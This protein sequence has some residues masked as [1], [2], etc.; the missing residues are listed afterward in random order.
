MDV[1]TGESEPESEWARRRARAS[2][3]DRHVEVLTEVGTSRARD[4]ERARARDEW[5]KKEKRGITRPR[6]EGEKRHGTKLQ[7]EDW[8]TKTFRKTHNSRET[9]LRSRA[10]LS[11]F[12]KYWKRRAYS[13]WGASS[14]MYTSAVAEAVGGRASAGG[15]NGRG[16]PEALNGKGTRRFISRGSIPMG[17]SFKQIS[18]HFQ[19]IFCG[20]T[21][22]FSECLRIS[23]SWHQCYQYP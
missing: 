10:G 18:K 21:A 16:Y 2:S 17:Y 20:M 15:S 5:C 1:L 3:T 11:E 23:W 13:G 8:R 7:V 12:E 19:N 22:A 4:W 6:E 14:P 9:K